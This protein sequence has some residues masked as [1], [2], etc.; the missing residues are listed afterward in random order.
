MK[1]TR[2]KPVS[3][4][5]AA[6]LRE[7]SKLRKAFLNEH[8]ICEACAKKRSAEIHHKKGR[9]GRW[10]LDTDYWAALCWNCHRKAHHVAT[11]F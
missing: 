10:L 1:R 5:R 3:K 8:P 2:L 4:K 9:F 6:Q 7:Y 11:G